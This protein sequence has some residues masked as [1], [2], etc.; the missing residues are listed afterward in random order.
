MLLPGPPVFE[1]PPAQA[2][3]GRHRRFLRLLLSG[4]GAENRRTGSRVPGKRLKIAL[5]LLFC[6]TAYFFAAGPAWKALFENQWEDVIR[7]RYTEKRHVLPPELLTGEVEVRDNAPNVF[8][9]II[10]ERQS[11]APYLEL[12]EERAPVPVGNPE[13]E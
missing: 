7:D 8:F 10:G 4:A 3:A 13:V 1:H 9:L 5:A 2:P 6:F 11:A 12:A